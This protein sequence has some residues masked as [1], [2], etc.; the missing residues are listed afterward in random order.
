MTLAGGNEKEELDGYEPGKTAADG[1]ESPSQSVV[2]TTGS[3]K[4]DGSEYPSPE[5]LPK[6]RWPPI[7]G[8]FIRRQVRFS[9]GNKQEYTYHSQ[10]V[11]C[12]TFC[13][14][15]VPWTSVPGIPK[16]RWNLRETRYMKTVMKT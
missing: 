10:P 8:V 9:E 3:P 4:N 7:R 5:E 1:L 6:E 11:P 12:A 15:G 14:I 16:L 2:D 13:S